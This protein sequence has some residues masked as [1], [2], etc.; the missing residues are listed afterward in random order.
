MTITSEYIHKAAKSLLDRC[1]TR[2]PFKIARELGINVWWRNDFV[3]LKGMYKVIERNR[4]IFVNSK[5]DEYERRLIIAHELGHDALH[6]EIAKNGAM[7]ELAFYDMKSRP[8]YEANVFAA[9]ILLDDDEVIE[10]AEGGYDERQIASWLC[11]DIN[12]LMIKMNE[13]NKRGYKFNISHTP[14]G[15]FLS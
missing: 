15:N 5:L 12:L 10:L 2:E 3:K 13:M 14:R 9:D 1:K 11:V 7:Q 4:F 6:R 8:E